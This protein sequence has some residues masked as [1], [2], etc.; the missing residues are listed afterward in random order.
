MRRRLGSLEFTVYQSC[1]M[2]VREAQ[3]EVRIVKLGLEKGTKGMFKSEITLGRVSVKQCCC[4]LTVSNLMLF[5][6]HDDLLIIAKVFAYV[7]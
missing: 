2:F 6:F 3:R 4:C 5:L 7:R 1:I